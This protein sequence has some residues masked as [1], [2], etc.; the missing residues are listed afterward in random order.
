MMRVSNGGQRRSQQRQTQ[1]WE[2]DSRH[3]QQEQQEEEEEEEPQSPLHYEQ[4][5]D[6]ADDGGLPM[7]PRSV[8]AMDSNQ[9]RKPY[10]S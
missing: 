9:Y 6:H 10:G 1:C 8:F 2:M 3:S 7:L 4:T 5:E